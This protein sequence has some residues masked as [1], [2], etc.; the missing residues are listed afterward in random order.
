MTGISRR[1][2]GQIRQAR[3][4]G[5][6]PTRFTA[7][8]VKA[9]CPGWAENTYSSFLPKHREGNPGGTTELFVRNSDGTYSLA[10]ESPL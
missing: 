4:E 2:I 8:D 1:F 10:E 6:L 5:K 9:A 7:A 3:R